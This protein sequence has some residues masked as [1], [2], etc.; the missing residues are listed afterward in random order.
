MTQPTIK[1]I[2]SGASVWQQDIVIPSYELGEP[3]KNPMFLEKRVYQG[4]SGKVYPHSVTDLFTDKKK[5][6]IYHAICMENPYLFIMILPELGGRIQRAY[7]KTNGYDFVYYNEVIKPAMVGLTGPWISG[8]IEFNWP[9]HH[10]P[11]TFDPIQ[12]I[13]RENSDG[14]VTAIVSEIENMFRTKG[15]ASFTLYP[16]KALLQI[17]VRLYNRT[18]QPQTFLWWANP[19]VTVNDYTQTVFPPDVHAVMDH[20]KRDVSRYPIATG[21]Y[22]K[23]DYSAG[24]DISRY[25]NIPVPTSFMAY[26]SDYDFVGGYDH[27]LEAGILHIAD[28]HFSPGKKQWT[29]GCGDF[30]K[31]WDRNLTDENGPYVELMTGCFTDNQPDF[32]W[33]MPGEEKNFTQ[34]FMPYKKIGVVKNANIHA[35]LNMEFLDDQKVLLQ[36][37]A[38][39]ALHDCRLILKNGNTTLLDQSIQLEPSQKMEK[40]LSIPADVFPEQLYLSL[41]AA[42][43]KEILNVKPEAEKIEQLPEAAKAIPDPQDVKTTEDLYLFGLHLEQYRH[44]TF[45]PE[46]YYLE[47]LQRDSSDSRINNAYG[48]LLLRRGKFTESEHYFRAAIRKLTRSNPN[49][50]DGEPFFNLGYSLWLQ[51]KIDEAYGAFYKSTWNSAWQNSGFYYLACIQTQKGNYQ[52]ALAHIEQSLIRN[53]HHMKARMLK[54]ALLRETSQFEK[55]RCFAEESLEIDPCDLGAMNELRLLGDKE[56]ERVLLEQ[57][58]IQPNWTI[59]LSLDYFTAGLYDQA[60]NILQTVIDLQGTGPVYPMLYY[61]LGLNLIQKGDS[62]AAQASFVEATKACSNYCFPHRL[63]DILALQCALRYH[64]A[65]AKGWYYLGNL[66]YDKRQYD[67]AVS[68]W[69]RSRELD[70]SFPTVHRNLSLAY[71]NKKNRPQDALTEMEEAYRLD[72]T[73]ARVLMELDQL[74]KKMQ[75]SPNER[76]AFLEAHSSITAIRDD[77][78]LEYI[79]LHNWFGHYQKALKLISGR[80]FHP[81]EGGEGKVP[82]QYFLS[83]CELAKEALKSHDAEVAIAYLNQALNYPENLGEGKLN[84]AKDNQIHYYLGEAYRMLGSDNKS[85]EQYQLASTGLTEP[86][87]MMF[88]NDLPPETIFY[89]GLALLRLEQLEAAFIR[90]NKLID[91]GEKHLFDKVQIDYFAVSLPDLM[92]F[93]DDLQIRNRVHCLF[94]AGLGWL[95]KNEWQKAQALFDEVSHLESYHFGIRFHFIPNDGDIH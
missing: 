68:C 88:Y 24:V 47:G 60:V 94:I 86:A 85:R 26:H 7:D 34:Y 82:A 66:W 44:A 72:E 52:T 14:S 30:G 75:I 63:E 25:K 5:E 32:S 59:E 40:T 87:G 91:Y 53:I 89:Q 71:F 29:W 1:M 95:G 36:L 79:A 77:L 50:Y 69:E 39:E 15:M 58:Q 13:I 93:E 4:S 3:D 16:D 6:K 10:R 35:A 8:G 41:L 45:L 67:D 80:H 90:F 48:S 84:D 11:S 49:P 28:H 61:H 17:N 92:V 38:P 64:A 22:Y 62:D 55:A 43:R 21:T 20:G 65:D 78:F 46:A 57:L 33:L 73:D 51:G 81:W 23:Q 2:T 18:N 42:D 54:T 74:R 56:S 9:Q 83:L 19:A 70:P 76:L 27:Q 31:A 12:G 37:Y